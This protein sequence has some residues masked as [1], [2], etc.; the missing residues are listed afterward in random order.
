MLTAPA[1]DWNVFKQIFTDHWDTFRQAHTRYQTP[2]YDE[3]VA[4]MLACGNP[5]R[6]GYVE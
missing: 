6:M 3:L 1:R 4:K 5:Q 2:Y